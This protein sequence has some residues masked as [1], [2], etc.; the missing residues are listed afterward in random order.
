MHISVLT[1][2]TGLIT[3]FTPQSCEDQVTSYMGVFVSA[4]S[5]YLSVSHLR[6]VAEARLS[7]A[8]YQKDETLLRILPGNPESHGA[9]PAP[10]PDT[11]GWRQRSPR[12][13]GP[14]PAPPTSH[15]SWVLKCGRGLIC[16]LGGGSVSVLSF[17]GTVTSR[18]CFPLATMW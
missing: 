4:Q 11:G 6:R 1:C 3:G 17:L 7:R 2:D 10:Q 14:L 12:I 13:R 18:T 16:A 15:G 5:I 9:Q 8:G